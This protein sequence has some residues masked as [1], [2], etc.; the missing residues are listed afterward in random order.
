MYGP[1][2]AARFLM[3]EREQRNVAGTREQVNHIYESLLLMIERNILVGIPY[4]IRVSI[5]P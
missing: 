3:G 1:V 2:H 5:Q 4:E